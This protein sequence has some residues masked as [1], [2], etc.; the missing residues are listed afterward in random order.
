MHSSVAQETAVVGQKTIGGVAYDRLATTRSDDPSTGGEYWIKENGDDTLDFAGFLHTEL[1]SGVLPSASTTFTAPI[2]VKIDPP[3][4]QPQ[5]VTATGIVA[6]G[7]SGAPTTAN[8][9]GQYTLTEQDATVAT[10]IGPVSGCNHYAGSATSDSAEIPA[11]LKGMTVSAELW[12][13]PS[14]GVVAFNSPTLGLG[15][16]M[17]GTDDCGEIDSSDY[18]I[19][20][21]VGVVDAS[22][23]FNLD[24]Y[25]CDGNEIAADKNTHASMLLELRWVDEAA[26][27]TDLEPRPIV[28]FGTPMG[29]FPSMGAESPASIFHPEENGKGFKY[30]Y[31]YVSQAAKNEIGNSTAYHISVRGVAGLSPVRVTARG[32]VPSR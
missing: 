29:Y 19:I 2:T 11:V 24:T 3:V 21:K 4:G 25:D 6:L 27:M 13:H 15:T 31:T 9:S 32:A 28:E 23:S 5:M 12:Y 7:D 30:W 18:R 26:A 16:A 14:Y 17:T 1:L 20:R 8:F 10:G 22:T